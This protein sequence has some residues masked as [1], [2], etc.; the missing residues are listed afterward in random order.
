MIVTVT[1]V[2][3]CGAQKSGVDVQRG[4]EVKAVQIEHVFDV[5]LAKMRNMLRRTRVHVFEPVR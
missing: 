4:V 3:G 1:M 2:M 5:H